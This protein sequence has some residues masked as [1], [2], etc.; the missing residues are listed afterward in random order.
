MKATIIILDM[1]VA[2]MALGRGQRKMSAF[3]ALLAVLNYIAL[4]AHGR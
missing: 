1:F 2:G 3:F 4:I